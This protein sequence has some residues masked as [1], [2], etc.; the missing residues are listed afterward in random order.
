MIS[1][2]GQEP[3][4]GERQ[5]GEPTLVSINPIEGDGDATFVA[6]LPGIGH[7]VG[8]GYPTRNRRNFRSLGV[9]E[10]SLPGVNSSKATICTNY[11]GSMGANDRAQ[12]RVSV[13]RG[14]WRAK[15]Y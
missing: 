10:T 12:Y 9:Y 4:S 6:T 11:S 13:R 8:L 14:L 2:S 15:R 1:L 3:T 5:R 7:D